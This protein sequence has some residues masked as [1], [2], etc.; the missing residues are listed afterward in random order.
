M[1]RGVIVDKLKYRISSP[2]KSEIAFNIVKRMNSD[3]KLNNQSVGFI[4]NWIKTGHDE[5]TKAYYDVWDI[6]LKNYMPQTRQILLDLVQ[7]D[8]MEK[9]RVLQEESGVLKSLTITEMNF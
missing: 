7:E 6:V 1:L 9:L 8:R 2:Q 4:K 3:E 5:K